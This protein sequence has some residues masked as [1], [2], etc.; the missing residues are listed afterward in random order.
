MA[1][2]LAV[3]YVP[4]EHPDRLHAEDAARLMYGSDVMLVQSMASWAEARNDYQSLVRDRRRREARDD[5]DE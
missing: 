4:G 2:W 5:D 1:K 3:C